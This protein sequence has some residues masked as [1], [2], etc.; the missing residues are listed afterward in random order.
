MPLTTVLV[1]FSLISCAAT[2]RTNEPP[3]KD[4][5]VENVALVK[6]QSGEYG[7]PLAK[8]INQNDGV[9][10]ECAN[11]TI[12]IISQDGSIISVDENCTA[13]LPLGIG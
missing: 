12:A 11:Y 3:Y 4:V 2:A 5:I 7:Y 6:G 1:L 10:A 8:I 9:W 13:L